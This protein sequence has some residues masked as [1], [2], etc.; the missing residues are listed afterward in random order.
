VQFRGGRSHF[1]GR[2]DHGRRFSR[3]HFRGPAF[4]FGFGFGPDYYYDYPTYA[5]YDDCWRLRRVH[6][7]YGWR[8]VRVNVCGD[9][10]GYY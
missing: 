2:F 7:R 3:R 9:Y 4:A 6:T 8:R 5:Y 10:Y 1:S